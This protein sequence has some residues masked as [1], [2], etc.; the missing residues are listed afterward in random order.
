[1]GQKFASYD[2][3]G[4]ITGYYDDAISA[5]PAGLQFVKLTADQY[6]AMLDGQSDG[7]RPSIDASGNP[8]LLDP[9]APTGDALAE[10]QRAARNAAITATDWI[11]ARHQD[12]LALGG[13][14][15]LTA[16]QYATLLAYRKTLRDLP[17]A[18]SW[19]DVELPAVPDFVTAM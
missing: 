13:A 15:T 10:L 14:T 6:R 9:P 1:M 3:T 18:S 2:A 4:A 11:V 12:E 5:P 17:D 7:K 8:V 19:P 16:E